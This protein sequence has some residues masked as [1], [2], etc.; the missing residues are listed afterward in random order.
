MN[1]SNTKSRI[2]DIT[3]VVDVVLLTLKVGELHVALVQRTNENEPA[4]GLWALPGG[5]IRNAEDEDT[6]AT[7]E[8]VLRDKAGLQSPYLEQ[9]SVF[10]GPAR[11]PDR[12]WTLCVAY[13]A[14]VSEGLLNGSKAVPLKLA[15]VRTLRGLPFDH[16]AIVEAA[17]ERVR[18]KSGYSTMPAYLCPE[19]FTLPQLHAVYQSV[20]GSPSNLASFR[21]K[22]IEMIKAGGIEEMP[23]AKQKP[24]LGKPAQLYRIN[25]KSFGTL[26]TRDRGV[27]G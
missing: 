7:A 24:T 16:K 23:G 12:G 2:N 8:R 10:S 20:R 9:L 6:L 4:F 1:S 27:A 5:F 18:T 19:E 22:F 25:P 3:C 26:I 13:C 15:N 11:D 14:L 17:V 21:R